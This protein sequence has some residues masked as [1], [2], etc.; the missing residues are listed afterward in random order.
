MDFRI[1]YQN[2]LIFKYTMY[3]TL[4]LFLIGFLLNRKNIIP[5]TSKF[6]MLV[7]YKIVDLIGPTFK[8]LIEG[9]FI[10]TVALPLSRFKVYGLFG[11]EVGG[12]GALCSISLLPIFM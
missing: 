4:I 1:V 11:S 2:N 8:W 12:S 7:S 9:L 5:Q 3:I 6:L 10:L